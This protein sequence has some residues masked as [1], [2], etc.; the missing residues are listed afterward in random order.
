MKKSTARQYSAGQYVSPC[1]YFQECSLQRLN[2]VFADLIFHRSGKVGHRLLWRL[3][4]RDDVLSRQADAVD[5]LRL[6]GARDDEASVCQRLASFGHLAVNGGVVEVAAI[7]K[8]ADRRRAAEIGFKR[9]AGAFG[10]E[11]R[12]NELERAGDIF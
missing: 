4:K 5:N 1:H 9:L 10:R 8:I 2:A 11:V 12:L 7:A 6:A 3:L